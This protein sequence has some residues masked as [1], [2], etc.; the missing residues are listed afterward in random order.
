MVIVI[1]N[2]TQ[3]ENGLAMS[4]DK[5]QLYTERTTGTVETVP[6]VYHSS[7]HNR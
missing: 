7:I 6:V 4:T 1:A 5:S 2:L 3:M